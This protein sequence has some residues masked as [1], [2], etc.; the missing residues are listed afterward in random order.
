MEYNCASMCE[1]RSLEEREGQQEKQ[2]L[3]LSVPQLY[4]AKPDSSAL[5]SLEFP[6]RLTA[7]AKPT[8]PALVRMGQ[9][10]GGLRLEGAGLGGS[11]LGGSHLSCGPLSEPVPTSESNS[12]WSVSG[13]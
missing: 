1:H 12:E 8:P 9:G 11:G 13:E 4:D 6:G 5:T 2:E 3:C 10:L 7:S